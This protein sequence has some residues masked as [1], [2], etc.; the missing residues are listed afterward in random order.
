[1]QGLT[2]QD[3]NRK[4]KRLNP[5]LWVDHSRIAYPYHKDYPTCG[6]YCGTKFIM[7]VPQKF[8]PEWTVGGADLKILEKRKRYEDLEYMLEKGFIP[9]GKEDSIE[10]RILWRGSRA[11]LASLARDRYID[12]RKVH[13]VF[14]FYIEKNRMQF[15]RYYVQ[16][17]IK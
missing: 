1:M 6:L 17:E 2:P 5:N 15:P 16:L 12:E 3:F 7:G 14:G 11:I 9:E 13:S 4:L 10:E 8:V